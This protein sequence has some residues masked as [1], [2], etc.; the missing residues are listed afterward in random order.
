MSYNPIA[1]KSIVLG[2]C[3]GIAAYKA[4]D[5]TSRLVKAG[6]T[7]EVIMTDGAQEFVAPLTFQA[8]THRPVATE[9][10]ALLAETE[11]GHVSLAKRA[12]VLVVAPATANTLAKL[13]VGLADNMLTTTALATRAPILCAPAMESAMW[14][15]PATRSNLAAL[16]ARGVAF[17]GPAEGRLASGAYGIGRMA[18]PQEIF[19]AVTLLLARHGDLADRHV[20]VTAGGTR[21]PIDP[22]RFVGNH[23]SGKMG[24]ALAQAA[25]DRGAAVTLVTTSAALVPP[26]GVSVVPVATADDMAGAVLERLNRIDALIM[27]A[28]VADYRPAQA[29]EHKIKKEAGGEELMLRLV[30]TIDILAEV[31][32]AR[33]HNP[34]PVVVGFAAET[35][36]LLAN[37]GV[38]LARKRLDLIAANDVS[39]PDSGFG[40]DTNRVTLLFPDGRIEPLPLLSKLD[41]AHEILTR[42]AALFGE[43]PASPA[44]VDAE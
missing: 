24:Y 19:D 22:V 18:E 3:G 21:E 30:R 37:A 11:I 17:V 31:A 40:A 4:A 39:A 44:P 36:D 10:F 16:K 20:L 5:L 23:S 25:R 32:V 2:V 38:K 41:V 43:A 8:L 12:D 6:A 34:S 33:G 15:S 7:V 26:A 14:D 42:V 13:A 28:A 35:Q 29:A 9:M 27:A 1:G